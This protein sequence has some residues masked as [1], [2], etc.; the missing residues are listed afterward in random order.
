MPP[1]RVARRER[2]RAQR[3]KALRLGIAVFAV[4]AVA[5]SI[6]IIARSVSDATDGAR[7]TVRARSAPTAPAPSSAAQSVDGPSAHDTTT[8][9]DG[10]S[11]LAY[12]P[13][14]A[15]ADTTLV[16]VPS[17]VG[18]TLPDAR[19]LL[20][21]ADLKADVDSGAGS[22]GSTKGV[23]PRTPPGGLRVRSQQPEAG[24]ISVAGA[25]VALS[26]GGQRAVPTKAAALP[27]VV[28][29]IDPGHQSH[30]NTAK[31]PIGP[32]SRTL[33]PKVT[34]GATG[35]STRVPEYEVALQISMNVRARLRR[36]GVKVVMTRTTNDVNLSNSQRAQVANRA[37]AALFLRIHANGSSDAR[38]AGISTLYPA[39]TRWTKATSGPSRRAALSVERAVLASTSAPSDG[40]HARSDLAGF[41]WC[42][43][44]SILVEC[45]YLSN[46]V[47][48]K[49]LTSPKYQD[50]V[51][52]GIA[53]GVLRYLGR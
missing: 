15:S 14:P 19:T 29:C 32:G 12:S 11:F 24:S 34:G 28:V 13:T 52:A 31:E 39:V 47:E 48:D 22:L 51:A 6:A 5:A 26:L 21:A 7:L 8:S 41:N 9:P 53:A 42:T 38:Q 25:T 45:G 40:V 37:R 10:E 35:V 2:A 49:L 50:K 17:V 20:A 18:R 27:T 36:A 46:P 44:P 43:R 23:R 30:S 4:V 16:E 33:K 3:R 1:S